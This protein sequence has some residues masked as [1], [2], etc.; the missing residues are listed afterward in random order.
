MFKKLF[1]L[2]MILSVAA[3]GT[4]TLYGQDEVELELQNGVNEYDGTRDNTIYDD[5]VTNSN[6]AGDFIFAGTTGR[7]AE[8]RALIAFD[9]ADV[10]EGATITSASLELTVSRT[11]SGDTA[12]FA[13]RLTADWGEGEENAGGQE[14]VGA[15]GQD[16]TATWNESFRNET[17]WENEGGDFAEEASASDDAGAVNSKVIL[18]GDSMVADVQAWVDGEADNFGWILL[19]VGTA[20]RFVGADRLD[21]EDKPK[22]TIVYTP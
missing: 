10:P 19:G 15:N 3:L 14:G 1:L 21:S 7:R 18:A 2:T 17:A 4:V 12:I 13:H 16:G 5:V 9:L 8:R 11:L 22:L 6:G 20:K